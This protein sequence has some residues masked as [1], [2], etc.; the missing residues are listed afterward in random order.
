MARRATVAR[1]LATAVIQRLCS[2]R[3][4]P[5]R[6]V[7]VLR[8]EHNHQEDME[9]QDNNWSYGDTKRACNSHRY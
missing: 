1:R 4:A 8:T 9:M 3:T 5:R 6:K 7:P 2:P